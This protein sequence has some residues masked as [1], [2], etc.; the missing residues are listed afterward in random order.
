MALCSKASL[1][2]GALHT[3]DPQGNLFLHVT[4]SVVTKRLKVVLL[5]FQDSFSKK[6]IRD[7][8]MGEML[9]EIHGVETPVAK[10][11]FCLLLQHG[12]LVWPNKMA[13]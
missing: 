5:L 9:L 2:H 8:R 12:N 11:N 4:L 7:K 13:C 3:D 6:G 10:R 1:F